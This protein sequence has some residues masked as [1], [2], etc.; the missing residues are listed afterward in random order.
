M[1]H[2]KVLIITPNH[3]TNNEEYENVAC[4]KRFLQNQADIVEISSYK[5]IK[6]FSSLN[7]LWR[8]NILKKTFLN[9]LFLKNLSY[10]IIN[11]DIVHI[12]CLSGSSFWGYVLPVIL[13]SGFFGKK[14]I[15]DYRNSNSLSN[16]NEKNFLYR[17]LF[18]LCKMILVLSDS[19]QQQINKLNLKS[20]FI[21]ESVELDKI[22]LRKIK[23]VQP[24]IIIYDTFEKNNFFT[25]IIKAFTIVKQKYPRTEMIVAT[26]G[27]RKKILESLISYEDVHG[28]SLVEMTDQNAR[29]QCFKEADIYLNCSQNDN[30]TRSILEALA[31]GLPVITTPIGFVD[32]FI[33]RQNVLYIRYPDYNSIA[34][35]IIEL[36]EN[37]VLV[38]K[39]SQEGRKTTE[40]YS[41][42]NIKQRWQKIYTEI[43][44]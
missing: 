19:Q 10:E 8:F 20:T 21:P 22:T 29:W 5:N 40:N 1:E 11:F 37:P 12:I 27:S 7:W 30:L 14:I 17:K 26:S 35:H 9:I 41:Y 34:S 43:R 31:F 3:L 24:K 25:G 4:L 18:C 44:Q 38:E 32:T 16:I 28:I 6:L 15:L 13:L 39:L 23:V 2:F 42:E 36:V 33:H